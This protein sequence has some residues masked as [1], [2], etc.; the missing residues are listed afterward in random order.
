MRQGASSWGQCSLRLFRSRAHSCSSAWAR[1]WCSR[2]DGRGLVPAVFAGA[3]PHLE[4]E[5][6]KTQG[7]VD[8]TAQQAPAANTAMTTLFHAERQEHGVADTY[9]CMYRRWHRTAGNPPSRGG[10]TYSAARHLT[11]VS[12]PQNSVPAGARKTISCQFSDRAR[13]KKVSRQDA[14]TRQGL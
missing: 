3:G 7:S 2:S 1:E 11:L 12:P 6:V 4:P 10:G 5:L 8:E 13:L 9:A 14:K